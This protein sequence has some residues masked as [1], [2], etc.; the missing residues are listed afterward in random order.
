MKNKKSYKVEEPDSQI[1]CMKS[2][3]SYS[4]SYS[5]T[6]INGKVVE[7]KSKEVSYDGKKVKVRKTKNGK[8]ESYEYEGDN[9]NQCLENDS[10]ANMNEH[11][12]TIFGPDSFFGKNMPEIKT[13]GNKK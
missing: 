4:E 6:I 5:T 2:H 10:F 13:L 7:Q 1:N 11:F 3:N 9:D 12:K 8:T